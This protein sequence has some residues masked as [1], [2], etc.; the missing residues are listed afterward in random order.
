MVPECKVVYVP[1]TICRMVPEERTCVRKEY[2]CRYV[3]EYRT[4]RTPVVHCRMVP[5]ECV[6]Q[7]PEVVCDWEA[8]TVCIK[9]PRCVP[10]CEPVCDAPAAPCG[11]VSAVTPMSHAEWYART[12]DKVRSVAQR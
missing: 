8:Y 12:M 9:V 6:K 1:Q 2:Y 10:I 7:V 4:C 5:E 3:T 11:P